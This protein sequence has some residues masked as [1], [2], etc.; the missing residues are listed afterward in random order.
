M[1][2]RWDE[3][4]KISDCIIHEWTKASAL[5]EGVMISHLAGLGEEFAKQIYIL[6]KVLSKC[7][8]LLRV[9]QC[10]IT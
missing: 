4:L 8:I 3:K 7:N 5:H 9:T 6:S 2:K 1:I 10:F